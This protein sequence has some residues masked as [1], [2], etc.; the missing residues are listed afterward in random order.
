LSSGPNVEM[1]MSTQSE[2]PDDAD[3]STDEYDKR[4]RREIE[5]ETGGVV[6]TE[7]G[8]RRYSAQVISN[9]GDRDAPTSV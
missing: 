1:S 8:R 9:S 4:T 6:Y 3:E 7:D 2:T 5:E